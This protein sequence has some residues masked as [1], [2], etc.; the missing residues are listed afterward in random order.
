MIIFII[1]EI[2][3]PDRLLLIEV[4]SK[5]RA[6][7]SFSLKDSRTG[8]KNIDKRTGKLE[9]T[10]RGKKRR[11]NSSPGYFQAKDEVLLRR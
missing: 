8:R 7:T 3:F 5:P 6:K 11:Q 1:T 4:T 10:N 2:N 9:V